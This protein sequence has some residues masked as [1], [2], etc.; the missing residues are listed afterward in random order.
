MD[1][2]FDGVS[3][4]SRAQKPIAGNNHSEEEEEEG[5]VFESYEGS[6]DDFDTFEATEEGDICRAE[7][8]IGMQSTHS[9]TK[10]KTGAFHAGADLDDYFFSSSEPINSHKNNEGNNYSLSSSKQD[11]NQRKK[12]ES[13]GPSFADEFEMVGFPDDNIRLGRNTSEQEENDDTDLAVVAPPEMPKEFYDHVETFLKKPPPK[14]KASKRFANDFPEGEGVVV[15]NKKVVK[16]KNAVVPKASSTKT[17]VMLLA[18]S[19]GKTKF[20]DE[21][22]LRQAFEYTDQLSKEAAVDEEMEA[23]EKLAA[24]AASED[25]RALATM[26]RLAR[27]GITV[28]SAPVVTM[29]Q[30]PRSAPPS[31]PISSKKG[32]SVALGSKKPGNATKGLSGISVVKRLRVQ[33]GGAITFSSRGDQFPSN[34]NREGSAGQGRA[35]SGGGFDVSGVAVEEDLRRNVLDFDALVANFEQGLTISKL[36]TELQQSKSAM[37][38]SEQFMRKLAQDYSVIGGGRSAK[39]AIRKR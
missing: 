2:N 23:A 17:T 36:K 6:N 9:P 32:P 24:A 13:S 38:A 33:T 35:T 34:N 22:L 7:E 5:E 27:S 19:K 28:N 4:R 31:V 3:L 15:A 29:G 21:D 20:I 37:E 1:F 25:K 14:M 12:K 10:L 16:K 26:N 8:S 11:G 39:G 18:G 30:Q